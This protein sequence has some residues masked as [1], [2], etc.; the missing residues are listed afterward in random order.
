MSASYPL[1]D[2]QRAG[3]T[4]GTALESDVWGAAR[5]AWPLR[6]VVGDVWGA[7]RGAWPLRV[8][9]GDGR[10]GPSPTGRTLLR[11]APAIGLEPITCR[12]TAGRS[13]VELRG[14]A[15]VPG[16]YGPAGRLQPNAFAGCSRPDSPSFLHPGAGT[17]SG[18][19]VLFRRTPPGAP[20]IG[21]EPITC[22]LTAGRS[23][24]ELRGITGRPV[25]RSVAPLP[26]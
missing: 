1:G 24:V 3:C 23:A 17:R 16:L 5:G 19:P 14:I 2:R 8:V 6:V 9:V 12:L 18:P 21:L 11:I 26:G 22:R 7:A 4:A 13:A 20:A 15:G 10:A 25:S